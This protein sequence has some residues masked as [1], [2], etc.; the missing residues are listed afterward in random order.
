MNPFPF[1]QRPVF[2]SRS[3][4]DYRSPGQQPFELIGGGGE[5]TS[6]AFFKRTFLRSFFRDSRS[7]VASGDIGPSLGAL[8]AKF[9]RVSTLSMRAK[10]DER[11]RPRAAVRILSPVLLLNFR[12]FPGALYSPSFHLRSLVLFVRVPP[13]IGFQLSLA[14][15]GR[16]STPLCNRT[17]PT[18]VFLGPGS[19]MLPVWRF[20]GLPPHGRASPKDLVLLTSS[21]LRASAEPE[22]PATLLSAPIWFGRAPYDPP[23]LRRLVLAERRQT[24]RPDDM[25][26]LSPPSV[27]RRCCVCPPLFDNVDCTGS[28]D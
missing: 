15:C 2:S 20:S 7:S 16:T 26:S 4:C 8:S 18:T 13:D 23:R 17:Q 25:A 5:P 19:N 12:F 24:R 3:Q 14:P 10:E 9:S 21:F 28:H 1:F 22:D 6:E 11:G 27:D